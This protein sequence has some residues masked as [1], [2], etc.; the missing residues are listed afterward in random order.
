M[1]VGIRL[2]SVVSALALIPV[3]LAGCGDSVTNPETVSVSISPPSASLAAGASQQ[4]TATV[5]GSAET[6]VTW[7]ASA[8]EISG[9]G[10]T[11]TYTAPATEGVHTLTA[12]SVADP[13]RSASSSITV[14]AAL[15]LAN[16]ISVPASGG[17]VV[18]DRPESAL[19]GLTIEVLAESFSTSTEWTIIEEPH[20]SPGLPTGMT[21]VGPAFRVRNGR[22]FAD[23]IFVLKIPVDVEAEE[24]PVAFFY[25]PVTGIFEL[26]PPLGL[27]EE[28]GQLWVMTRHVS[29]DNLLRPEAGGAAFARAAGSSIRRND[30]VEQ[31]FGE[32]TILTVKPSPTGLLGEAHTSFAPGVDDW[33]FPN[34]GSYLSPNGFCGGST[35]TAMHHHY[36]FKSSK[37][38]L[39]ELYDEI[40]DAWEDSGRGIRLASVV[41]EAVDWDAY[42]KHILRSSMVPVGGE[43]SLP[44]IQAV[45]LATAIQLTGLPQ[46]VGIHT[47]TWGAGHALVAYGFRDGVFLVADPNAPGENREIRWGG[48]HWVWGDEWEPFSFS[49]RL[50]GPVH[51]YTRVVPVGVS[52]LVDIKALEGYWQQFDDGTIGDDIFP[53]GDLQFRDPLAGTDW[54]TVGD[55]VRT[56][57]DTLI[58]RWLCGECGYQRDFDPNDAPR[59]LTLLMGPGPGL[60]PLGEDSSNDVEGAILLPEEGYQRVG[61]TN[62]AITLNPVLDWSFVNFRWITVHRVPFTVTADNETPGVNEEV[63]FTVNEEALEGIE[64]RLRWDFGDGSVTQTTGVYGAKHA[65]EAPGSYEVIVD[66]LDEEGASLAKA[67]VEIRVGGPSYWIG[68]ATAV[69]T[70]DYGDFYEIRL[71]ASNVRFERSE[72][73]SGVARFNLVAGSVFASATGSSQTYTEGGPCTYSA[74]DIHLP[75]LPGEG[76]LWFVEQGGGPFR[77]H[78]WGAT[79]EFIVNLTFA[80]PNRDPVVYPTPMSNWLRTSERLGPEDWVESADR[81]RITGEFRMEN[82]IPG[83]T[84]TWTWS[85]DFHSTSE[86]P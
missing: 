18:V 84:I 48:S 69:L 49:A 8:G 31:P 29:A 64:P 26:I 6:G 65:Y 24:V 59:Q 56:A 37:G 10:N 40:E 23:D 16:R 55:T 74:A 12:T 47:H 54:Q 67:S 45:S 21:Q 46:L 52:T 5:T 42:T 85:W 73:V 62:A 78:G 50:D 3:L 2:R 68:T 1:S 53:A 66:L 63:T 83:G 71:E 70:Y 25:D 38:S 4:F 32:V 41:Q 72:D 9:S 30:V 86:A 58:F 27:D 13:A 44:Y 61:V 34:R 22:G 77:Y 60:V 33:E 35:I 14:D 79:E 75:V 51:I 39:F 76:S 82:P 80:C 11:V 19:H 43:Y 15:V 17:Q 20:V 28:K 81:E 57:G 36:A 7:T